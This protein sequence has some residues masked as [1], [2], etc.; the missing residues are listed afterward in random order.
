MMTLKFKAPYVWYSH[1]DI[2]ESEYQ[3]SGA[4]DFARFSEQVILVLIFI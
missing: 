1:S 3:T 4:L 2:M